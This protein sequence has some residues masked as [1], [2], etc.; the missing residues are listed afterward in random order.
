MND[1]SEKLTP[2]ERREWHFCWD[3]DGLLIHRDDPEF[4]CCV[5]G[6]GAL[7]R[8]ASTKAIR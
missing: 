3:W 4:E 2:E 7:I 6:Q 1:P 5:C 8:A